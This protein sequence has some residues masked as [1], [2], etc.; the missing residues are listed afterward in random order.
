MKLKPKFHHAVTLAALLAM[1]AW[2]LDINLPEETATF[3]ASTLPGYQLVQQNCLT[4]HSAHYPQMQPGSS[5]RTYWEAT[6][7]KM[8]KPFGAQFSDDDIPAMVDYLVKTY[9]AEKTVTAGQ[10]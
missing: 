9:G 3:R 1:P 6:V 5:P 10:K 4:C 8:K 2:A 7:K